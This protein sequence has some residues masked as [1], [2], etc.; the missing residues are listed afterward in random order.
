MVIGIKT[1]TE[2]WNRIEKLRNKSTLY[3]VHEFMTKEARIYSEE[4]TAS[5]INGIEKTGPLSY[6]T[7]KNSLKMN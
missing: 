3:M 4:R 2:Q 1:D 7:H 6:T 5:S